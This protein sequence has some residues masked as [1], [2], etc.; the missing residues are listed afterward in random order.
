MSFA[1]QMS[2]TR[3]AWYRADSGILRTAYTREICHSPR[4]RFAG[5]A[6]GTSPQW[7]REACAAWIMRSSSSM[8]RFSCSMSRQVSLNSW[9]ASSRPSVTDPVP[10]ALFA[11]AEFAMETAYDPRRDHRYARHRV[12]PAG[13][14]GPCVLRRRA[15]YAVGGRGRRMAYIRAA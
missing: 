12:L 7:Y 15:R 9:A 1:W 4:A 8:V 2:R 14:A 13:G 10:G 3:C 6:P 11:V 5:V